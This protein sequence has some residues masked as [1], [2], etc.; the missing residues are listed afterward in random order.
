MPTKVSKENEPW[1]AIENDETSAPLGNPL[2]IAFRLSTT[3]SFKNC[4]GDFLYK[5]WMDCFR[6]FVQEFSCETLDDIS[7]IISLQKKSLR[8]L[9]MDYYRNPSRVSEKSSTNS[10]QIIPP[11]IP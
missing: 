2:S 1:I 6:D 9:F 7:S 4:T 3:E 10:F 11:T 8:N 5:L